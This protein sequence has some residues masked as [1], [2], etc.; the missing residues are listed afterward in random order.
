MEYIE[1]VNIILLRRARAVSGN[2]DAALAESVW[3]IMKLL[4]WAQ[5]VRKLAEDGEYRMNDDEIEEAVKGSRDL[6]CWF[7]DLEGEAALENLWEGKWINGGLVF[8]DEDLTTGDDQNA[9]L[10]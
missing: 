5:Q 8:C 3:C 7:L 10:D 9:S 2:H 6:T 4:T 1:L